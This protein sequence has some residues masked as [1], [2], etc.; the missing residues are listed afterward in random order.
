M[1]CYILLFIRNRTPVGVL[2]VLHVINTKLRTKFEVHLGRSL[3]SNNEHMSRNISR[4][5]NSKTC[6]RWPLSKRPKMVFKTNYS[7]MQVKS[8]AECSILM[9]ARL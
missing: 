2:T 4:H 8:I 3:T 7:L 9:L 1:F 5:V 6:A